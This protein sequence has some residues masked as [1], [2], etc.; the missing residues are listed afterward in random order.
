MHDGNRVKSVQCM[1]VELV[2][3]SGN[4]PWYTSIENINQ[5]NFK[6]HFMYV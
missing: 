3:A 5:L 4:I 1:M 6:G 2:V